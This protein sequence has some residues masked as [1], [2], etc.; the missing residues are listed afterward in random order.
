MNRP[1]L[2]W[3][4]A[5]GVVVPLSTTSA[6]GQCSSNPYGDDT[7]P[8]CASADPHT[9]QCFEVALIS[10]KC[11]QYD[12][13]YR[14][15]KVTVSFEHSD[16]TVIPTT[17][18]WDRRDGKV[19]NCDT[20]RARVVFPKAGEWTWASSCQT[21]GSEPVGCEDDSGL[22]LSAAQTPE[23]TVT[24]SDPGHP[25]F[26]HGFLRSLDSSL[27]P[28]GGGGPVYR[29]SWLQHTD[30]SPFHWLG[31]SA[32]A[33]A[34][35]AI[36]RDWKHYV[37]NRAAMGFTVIH[38]A[39]APSSW[40]GCTN[41]AGL[42]PFDPGS[43][44]CADKNLQRR[45]FASYTLDPP[46]QSGT[47]VPTAES[48]PIAAF[49][50]QF[51]GMV[52]YA[53]DRGLVVFV[54]GVATP[55]DA[56]PLTVNAQVFARYL[57]ARLAGNFVI[58][59]PGF[60]DGIMQRDDN[61]QI[62]PTAIAPL[63]RAVGQEIHLTAPTTLV[64][65]HPGTHN[66]GT[67]PADNIDL[68]VAAAVAYADED[69]LAFSMTQSGH[70]GGRLGR[71]TYRAKNQ[72]YAVR[73]YGGTSPDLPMR[74]V[75]NP[76]AI[77]DHGQ[78]ADN[79][80]GETQFSRG[81]SRQAGYYSLLSGA[82]GYSMGVLGVW[83][84]GMCGGTGDPGP[85]SWCD[86]PSEPAPLPTSDDYRAY[87][88][89][90][91]QASSNDAQLMKLVLTDPDISLASL[92]PADLACSALPP[93]DLIYY[94]LCL[95][96]AQDPAYHKKVVLQRDSDTVLAYLPENNGLT[97][98]THPNWA[99]SRSAVFRN[100]RTGAES[101]LMSELP[102]EFRY[103]WDLPGDPVSGVAN[104]WVMEFQVYPAMQTEWAGKSANRLEAVALAPAGEDGSVI[105]LAFDEE[106]SL[107]Q[108]TK[109]KDLASG[110]RASEFA[111]A[112]DGSGGFILVW[113]EL[114]D[115]P[116]PVRDRIVAQR[117]DSSG[118][119]D[120]Q[121]ITVAMEAPHALFEP[122][123]ATNS[124][125]DFVV[126]WRATPVL[127]PQAIHWQRYSALDEP[128][129]PPSELLAVGD[130]VPS[131]PHVG[132][133]PS[134]DCM[135]TWSELMPGLESVEIAAATFQLS[136][137]AVGDRILA[138]AHSPADLGL[139]MIRTNALGESRVVWEERATPS[140]STLF[141][142]AFDVQGNAL[143]EKALVPVE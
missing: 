39:M 45:P 114:G 128:I 47:N 141:Y 126:A 25:L 14:N 69:W 112:R 111:A 2:K 32:W 13:A 67:E 48:R 37:D 81:R 72:P 95:Y 122:D 7:L 133:S 30:G 26:S 61:G 109:L 31:D 106:G 118:S 54:P 104:D 27:P 115:G 88:R 36:P 99:L 82:A 11:G 84:W 33:A 137:G 12:N 52:Q 73:H 110:V 123:V 132:C 56:Y 125:G 117:L 44:I 92:M 22:V 142:R 119:P 18:F 83:E 62:V 85:A 124:D 53:N 101:V 140:L 75:V 78:N 98:R 90:M 70:N 9:W 20:Y 130:G 135:L 46:S 65:N 94:I 127:V 28:I 138:T 60:D 76:E 129:G 71:I 74:S 38:L 40:I 96:S 68:A 103:T 120:G 59:S 97:L 86:D 108:Q 77:Y 102:A 139:F 93:G 43:T 134:G 6:V 21:L 143:A 107:L 87:N 55:V 16:G 49:W 50:D 80:D 91:C 100:P 41:H 121:E 51:D 23:I 4:A 136:T 89:A 1:L 29:K 35:Q 66:R 116:A 131:N 24:A 105:V 79:N 17:A 113:K 10:G 19:S 58:L 34:M 57:A 42:E 15:L 63:L 5:I 64:T 8:S 3:V